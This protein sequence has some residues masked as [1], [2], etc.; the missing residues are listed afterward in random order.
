LSSFDD[1]LIF[2]S[3]ISV[4]DAGLARV[5]GIKYFFSQFTRKRRKRMTLT[6]RIRERSYRKRNIE[7]LIAWGIFLGLAILAAILLRG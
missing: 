3:V 6:K 5:G 2:N 7:E 1:F 4:I